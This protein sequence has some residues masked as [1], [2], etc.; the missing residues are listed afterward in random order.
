MCT[1]DK[2]SLVCRR[3]THYS[4]GFNGKEKDDEVKGSGNSY[5][6]GARIYDSRLG[7]WQSIDPL[8]YKYPGFSPY[9]FALNNPIVLLDPAGGDVI[10]ADAY[11]QEGKYKA[12]FDL[13]S[14]EK[15]AQ[16]LLSR[17]ETGKLKDQVLYF[18]TDAS[19]QIPGETTFGVL[20]QEGGKEVFKSL[21]NESLTKNSKYITKDAKFQ[22]NVA[23]KPRNAGDGAAILNHEAF[24][25]AKDL[26]DVT[27]KLKSGT[28]TEEVFKTTVKGLTDNMENKY[29]DVKNPA[30]DLNK[31]QGQLIEVIDKKI[32]G[33]QK[34]GDKAAEGEA[35]STKKSAEKTI[36]A[37]KDANP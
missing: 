4:Y 26:A 34:S 2:S 20:V 21:D 23:L 5:D 31:A 13:W 8:A 10:K 11:S 7:K 1:E 37:D 17:F 30:S 36:Q 16:E 33:A 32:S 12:S 22:I 28:I 6:F 29:K 9:N 25:W 27:E 19:N 15:V 3:T 18:S 14:E 24:L 35:K